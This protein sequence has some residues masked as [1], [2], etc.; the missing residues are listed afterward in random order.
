MNM[1]PT[2]L[3]LGL[4]VLILLAVAV[5]L[6]MRNRRTT[7]IKSRFGSEF[8]HTVHKVGGEQK[9]VDLLAE[10][11]K[12]VASYKIKPLRPESRSDFVERWRKVQSEFVDSPNSAVTHADDLL[13]EVMSA[14]GYPVEDFEHRAEDIS[15]DHPEL[16]Q[17]YRTAHDI[18]ERHARGEAS[19]ED[20]R[21]AMIHYRSLFDDLVKE[22]Q[23]ASSKDTLKSQEKSHGR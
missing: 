21:N 19:T 13:G 1:T 18:A 6:W 10:R 11:E 8:D 12:R 4:L 22:P 3:V 5:W 23:A 15:V 17:S 9:A 2:E 14:R 16:V 20:L 7:E